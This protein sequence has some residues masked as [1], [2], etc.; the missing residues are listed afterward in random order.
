MVYSGPLYFCLILQAFFMTLA[1]SATIYQLSPLEMTRLATESTLWEQLSLDFSQENRP[2]QNRQVSFSE[3]RIDILHPKTHSKRYKNHALDHIHILLDAPV[4]PAPKPVPSEPPVPI[5]NPTE[6]VPQPIIRTPKNVEILSRSV[7]HTQ[8]KSQAPRPLYKQLFAVGITLVLLALA[9]LTKAILP[10]AKAEL[11][12]RMRAY[13]AKQAT[14]GVPASVPKIFNPLIAPN[15][16]EIT[17]VDTNFGIVVPSIGINSPVIPAV[18]PTNKKDYE[19]ALQHGVAHAATSFFPNEN[20]VVYLFSH[21][22][23][24]DWFVKDLNAVFYLLKNLQPGDPIV[25]L[26]QGKR[27]TYTLREKQI[28]GPSE[29]GY[30]MPVYGKKMLVLQT[31]WPPGSVEKRLLLF[32]DFVEEANL[33]I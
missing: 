11:S 20:G 6:S 25:L 8:I 23:N 7:E 4:S 1:R 10:T 24:Y 26:Y 31:C 3:P 22:T 29:V 2:N 18:D 9:G 13:A 32:A 19:E 33:E 5:Q 15:G 28:V 27:Y 14:S 21:S 30:M 17:P 16:S 12:Y